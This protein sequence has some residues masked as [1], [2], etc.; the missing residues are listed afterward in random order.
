ME[1]GLEDREERENKMEDQ[2]EDVRNGQHCP[3]EL[4]G[5]YLV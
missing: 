5:R 3:P 1:E 4:E 2:V